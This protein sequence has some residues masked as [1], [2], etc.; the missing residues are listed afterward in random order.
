[1]IVDTTRA[2]GILCAFFRWGEAD[3]LQ[4]AVQKLRAVGDV[5]LYGTDSFSWLLSRLCG[6]VAEDYTKRALRSLLA[7]FESGMGNPGK[8][9]LGRYLRY[10]YLSRRSLAWPSQ[11]QGIE[12]LRSGQSFVLCT[13]TGSGKTAVAELAILQALFDAASTPGL[14]NSLI[15]PELPIALYLV[16]SR[17]L[18]AEVESKLSRVLHRL[19]GEQVVVTGLYGGTDWGPTDA[20]LTAEDRTVLICTYEKAEALMRFLGPLFLHRVNLL[21]VDEAHQVQFD[22]FVADLRRGENR[23]LRLEALAMRMFNY[24]DPQRCRVIALS[25]VASGIEDA[26]SGWVTGHPGATPAHS[27]YRSTRQLI[28]RLECQPNRHY[29]IRYDLLDGARL[30]FAGSRTSEATP[31]I[32]DPFPPHPPVS[33][34]R[35]QGVEKRLRPALF[36]A[37]M[38]LATP[39][40]SGY[41]HGVLI[42]VTEK[43]ADYAEDF[44]KLLESDWQSETCPA[45]FQEPEE[46]AK[47]EL[48]Q[49]CCRC[50]EDYLGADS[51]E[52]RMLRKGVVVHHGKMPGLTA[53]LL[54]EVVQEGIVDLVLA[55]STLS[56]GV[57]L[58]IHTILIPTLRRGAGEMNA[59]EFSN[60]VG[61][62]GRPGFAVEGRTLVLV[63]DD[64]RQTRRYRSLINTLAA[65]TGATN[66]PSVPQSAL[67]E[68]LRTIWNEWQFM[69]G[70]SDPQVFFDWLETT[71]PLTIRAES[72][73]TQPVSSVVEPLDTL[74]GLLLSAVVEQEQI[75]GHIPPSPRE[76]EDRLQQLWQ[77]SFAVYTGVTQPI[78][79]Q[80]F[81]RRGKAIRDVIYT[82]PVE[83]RNLYRTCL[84]PRSGSQ[85]LASYPAI[86]RT[87]QG[88]QDY[89]A[90][91]SEMKL[92]FITRL[93]EQ[94]GTIDRFQFAA[95][96][97]RRT[98]DWKDIL[99]WWLTPASATVRPEAKRVSEWH[100]YVYKN[101][102]YRFNWG[103]GS[104]IALAT[105]QVHQG[106]LLPTRLEEWPQTG[107]PWIAF[108]IKELITWGTLEPVAAYLLARGRADTRVAAEAFAAEYTRTASTSSTDPLDPVAIR[109]WVEQ[110]MIPTPEP[111]PVGPPRA[112][113]VELLADFSRQ[114][115]TVAWRVVPVPVGD[116]LLWY[117]PA[118]FALAESPYQEDNWNSSFFTRFDFVLDAVHAK[119]TAEPYL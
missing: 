79:E 86:C 104:I 105:D 61:R 23:T 6:D 33:Q 71:A 16:P 87:L 94:V 108:W 51:L 18:A 62:A 38:H 106:E 26:L 32:P 10:A 65:V 30:E 100:D 9:A 28:G 118:G 3:R 69:T 98:V 96:V 97:G 64:A 22:G 83:R 68:L 29:A 8:I 102:V 63:S 2:L 85:L 90:W 53:R 7:G 112:I 42:S 91:D 60:L 48:W 59:R 89:P 117:D 81:L 21:V 70:S 35:W 1:V 46:P 12:R 67:A 88:G 31:F 116:K 43:P 76:V 14:L 103:Y 84:P 109:R 58:P 56:E 5:L 34:R 93:L 80:T 111:Q 41:R 27:D 77:R 20:W 115:N 50:C 39:D 49:K 47:R 40:E 72:S 78:L 19:S 54:V 36:W 37:A 4:N 74:D 110:V 45:F 13:P 15:R 114:T 17:A 75:P 57:N 107:L 24:V 25:A 99:K 66:R 55:T 95:K 82:D 119:V 101:F 11:A 92:R 44:L 73:S 52:F 113:H